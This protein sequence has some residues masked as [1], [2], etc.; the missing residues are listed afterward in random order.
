MD[1]SNMKHLRY[2]TTA[3]VFAAIIFISTYFLQIKIGNG[4]IHPGDTFIYLVAC[5]LPTPYAAAAAAIGAALSDSLAAP[6]YIPATLVI[7]AV[8]TLFFT[9]KSVKI[10]NKRNVVAVFL[11]GITGLTGYFLWEWIWF[12]LYTAAFD[13]FWGSL[14]PIGSGILFVLVGHALDK[15]NMKKRLKL[16]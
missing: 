13:A 3:G 12:G 16:N 2:L 4:Y 9:Y 7:K 5:I 11:A 10:I 1:N 14:Q 15:T 6:I 8:L